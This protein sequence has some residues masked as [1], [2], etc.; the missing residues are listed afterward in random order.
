M[1]ETHDYLVPDYYEHF[2][3]KMGA[4]RS[5]C[6]VGWPIS[7]SMQDYF[8]LLGV[9]CSPELRR[10]LDCAMHMTDHPTQE[11]YAQITPRYDGNCPLRQPDGRCAVHAEL[12]EE[13]LALI[14]RLYPRGPHG[15]GDYECSCANSCEA[16]L[17]MLLHHD[18]PLTFHKIPLT[19]DL[20]D[21]AGRTV[22]FETVGR[23]Q[24]IRLFFIRI[25]QNR[26]LPMPQR[27]ISLGL[28]L[29]AVE[30]ALDAVDA[31]AIDRLLKGEPIHVPPLDSEV[32]RAQLDFG[33]RAA[34]QML[35]ILDER[36]QSI[37]DYGEACLAYFGSDEQT[38]SRYLDAR[39]HFEARFPRW[40]IWF[41]HMLV[42]HMFFERFPFQDRPESLYDEFIAICA[43]YTVLRF[44]A[45]GWMADKEDES[46]LVDVAAAAFRLID[47]TFFDRTASHILKG[48]GCS[49]PEQ[50]HALIRL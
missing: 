43:V 4:C 23:E 42:N 8:H 37:R 49:R 36:S 45:I 7:V 9:D 13:A 26:A 5:A 27:I 30:E 28:S 12:G 11:C 33:L 18:A 17:E 10:R 16:V 6:C 31:E 35:Q 41:E 14:C 20:P 3:C 40:E 39:S 2:Q 32:D 24:E 21:Y 19:F 47:H 15:E 22:F 29:K 44:L 48:L 1:K 38:L 34:E 25:L 50:L 46:S